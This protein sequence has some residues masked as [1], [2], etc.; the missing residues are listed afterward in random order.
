MLNVK[1]RA[2]LPPKYVYR[3]IY[4]HSVSLRDQCAIPR[5][6]TITPLPVFARNES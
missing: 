4:K 3:G 6:R 1:H 2:A 5:Q